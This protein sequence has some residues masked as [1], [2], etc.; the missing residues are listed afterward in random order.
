MNTIT[1]N[2]AWKIFMIAQDV[3]DMCNDSAMLCLSDARA[4]YKANEFDASARHAFKSLAYSVG[5]FDSA[6]KAAAAL[7]PTLDPWRG[8]VMAASKKLYTAV[9]ETFGREFYHAGNDEIR[10]TILIVASAIA[11][12]FKADNANFNEDKFVAH[13]MSFA[14]KLE[15]QAT[16]RAI[17][18]ANRAAGR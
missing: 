9:A 12:D 16:A 11:E 13:M 8:A 5:V 7:A 15:R 6:Y 3:V 18:M 2:T 14:D 4:M 1:K 10:A 17:E